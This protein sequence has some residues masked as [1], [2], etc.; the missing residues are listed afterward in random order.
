MVEQELKTTH[1]YLLKVLEARNRHL[2]YMLFM[3]LQKPLGENPSHV[4]QLLVAP[5]FSLAW[6]HLH[7]LPP[8]PH[9]SLCLSSPH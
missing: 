4:L 7:P 9:G 8:Y 5:G 1:I 2:R 6:L 3:L